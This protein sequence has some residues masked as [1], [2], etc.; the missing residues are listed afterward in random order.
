MITPGVIVVE[1]SMA[2]IQVASARR[3]RAIVRKA[4]DVGETIPVAGGLGVVLTIDVV[5]RGHRAAFQFVAGRLPPEQRWVGQ[6][7]LP[8]QRVAQTRAH[9][10]L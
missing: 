2:D 1:K 3:L 8:A 10:N 5:M 9:R 7:H 6:L 4:A